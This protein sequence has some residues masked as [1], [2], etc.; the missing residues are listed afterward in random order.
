MKNFFPVLIVL[1]T[2]LTGC[3]DKVKITGQVKFDDGEPVNFGQVI[4]D[5][6]NKSFFGNIRKDGHYAPGEIKDGDGVPYGTYKVWLAGTVLSEEGKE[7]GEGE[8]SSRADAKETY[9][10]NE[11]YTSAGKTDITFEVKKGGAKTFDFTVG[12]PPKSGKAVI[13]K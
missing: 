13:K 2:L 1:L 3:S 6:N 8:N 12:R 7:I 9:R 10:V 5:G 4:F 11:K